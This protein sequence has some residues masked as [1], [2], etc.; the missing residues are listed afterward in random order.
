MRMKHRYSY[1]NSIKSS[2]SDELI[3]TYLLRPAAGLIVWPLFYTPVTPNQVTVASVIAG[4]SAAFAYAQGTPKAFFAAGLLVTLKDLLDSADGQLARA[5]NQYSRIGRFLD[6]IGD[7]IV[8]AAIFG[9]LGWLLYRL[10]GNPWM[11]VLAFLG[12]LGI[13]FR[14]SYHVFY[15]AH[16]L[17]LR[18]TYANNRITEEVREEDV[19]KG[20]WELQMQRLFQLLYGWQD[21]AVMRI[22]AWTARTRLRTALR[23]ARTAKDRQFLKRWYS[24]LT[25]LRL[26]GFLGFGSE[27]FVLTVCSLCNKLETYLYINLFLMNGILL[28]CVIYRRAILFPRIQCGG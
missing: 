27:L 3:N 26:S 5:K 9:V 19:K 13:S 28:S 8:D 7:F 20:G 2:V 24:D 15:H 10:E 23:K 4:L 11:L 6:S 16:Y 18:N 21:R 25:G 1:R 17:H 14:V 22:D 12:F